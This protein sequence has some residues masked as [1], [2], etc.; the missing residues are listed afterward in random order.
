M[1]KIC[2]ISDLHLSSNP[3]VWKE[4]NSLARN[5]YQV[6]VLTMW[7]SAEKKIKDQAFVKHPNLSYK[8]FLSL[9]PGETREWIRFYQR[10]R[11]RLGREVTRFLPV[12]TKWALGYGLDKSVKAAKKEKAD[13]YIAHT[14]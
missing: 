5:G 3:R 2:I 6:V 13:L 10:L 7:S 11:F 9:I 4:A 1:K 14:E 12:E 8:A